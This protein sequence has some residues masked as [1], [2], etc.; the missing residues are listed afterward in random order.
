MYDLTVVDFTPV[1]T[2]FYIVDKLLDVSKG[3][4]FGLYK[5][6]HRNLYYVTREHRRTE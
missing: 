6:F 4:N 5:S 3:L 2:P 1:E